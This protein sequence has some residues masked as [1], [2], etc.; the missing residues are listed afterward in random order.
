MKSWKSAKGFTLIE[1]LVVISI[2]SLLASIVLA[3]INGTRQKASL[4]AA[5]EF[6]AS[7]Y[8]L[9]GSDAYALWDFDEGSGSSA[10]DS[11]GNNF[12]FTFNSAPTWI[13]GALGRGYAVTLSNHYGTTATNPNVSIPA[14]N[15]GANIS[16]GAWIKTSSTATQF[17]ASVDGTVGLSPGYNFSLCLSNGVVDF[18]MNWGVSGCNVGA[19]SLK[20]VSDGIWHYVLVSVDMNKVVSIY[21]DSKL[22]R[23]V[24]FSHPTGSFGNGMSSI[25]F[26]VGENPYPPNGFTVVGSL[27]EV[28]VYGHSVT[29][30]EAQE[31]YAEGLPRHQ[32][33]DATSI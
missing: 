24:P 23:S 19:G 32:V 31:L 22:D 30:G 13:T 7:A 5:K 11:S 29:L 33:A 10:T 2:I 21:V 16:I 28:H 17:I 26:V 20:N 27:D 4:A 15:G 14:S 9:F 6:S 18:Y 25:F 3:S 8:H 12:G 1:L